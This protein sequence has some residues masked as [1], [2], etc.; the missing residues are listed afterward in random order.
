MR[1]I[2]SGNRPPVQRARREELKSATIREFNGGWNVIDSELSLTSEYAVRLRNMFRHPDGSL[3]VRYGTRLFAS[4]SVALGADIVNM[5]YFNGFIVAVGTNGNVSATDGTGTSYRLWDNDIAGALPSSPVGW[6]TTTFASFTQFKGELIICNGVDKPLLLNRSMGM[7]YLQDLA[8][9]TNANTPV[10]R[11]VATHK[12]F[13]IIAGDPLAPSTI[14]ISARRTS[15]TY[16]GDPSSDG[17]SLDLAAYISSGTADIVG[18][19]AFRDRLLVM[20]DTNTVIVVLGEYDSATHVPRV[21]D[22]IAEHGSVSHRSMQWL[23]DDVLYADV[24][25]AASVKRALFTQTIQPNHPSE[26]IKPAIQK[27]LSRLSVTSRE[28]RV[29]SVYD[30]LASQYIM[31]IPNTDNEVDTLETR[32]FVYTLIETL[33]VKAWSEF[34]EMKWSAACVSQEKRV[35]YAAGDE[36]FISG[37]ANDVI[38]GDRV[39]SEETFSDGTTFTDQTGFFPVFDGVHQGIPIIFDWELP[40]SDFDHRTLKKDVK[41]MSMDVEGTGRF[42]AELYVD[43]LYRDRTDLGE[44]FTDETLF[45]D[46]FGFIAYRDEPVRTPAL[47]LEFVGGDALGFGS[48]FGNYFGGGRNT[49]E[50][51]LWGFEASG[52]LFKLRF[53]GETVEPLRFVSTSLLYQLKTIRR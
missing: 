46:D 14:H 49:Q 19:I 5:A 27:D 23:G 10:G 6:G 1:P 21:D 3:G 48:M 24:A 30:P 35:F 2:T 7:D 47:S 37:N 41:Y 36:I 28:D 32:G 16:E 31:F 39:G 25:G 8:T 15:G 52:K 45:S 20:F 4:L 26:L 22:V 29:L 9:L 53:S 43:N 11:Y 18:M 38:S 34:T 51:M 40:W 50:E 33:K 12:Q 44:S 13:V 42:T 17:T